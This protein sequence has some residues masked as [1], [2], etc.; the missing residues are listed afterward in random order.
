MA[1]LCTSELSFLVFLYTIELLLQRKR[2]HI[3]VEMQASNESKDMDGIVEGLAQLDAENPYF[4]VSM[5][6]EKE[7]L[8]RRLVNKTNLLLRVGL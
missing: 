1:K 2:P 6:Q 4:D 7:F 8:V 3:C 5:H